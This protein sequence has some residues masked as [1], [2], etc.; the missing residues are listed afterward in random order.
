MLVALADP[1]HALPVQGRGQS[2]GWAGSGILTEATVLIRVLCPFPRLPA[3]G[4]GSVQAD[5]GLHFD[6]VLQGDSGTY[7]CVVTNAAGSQHRDVELIV[8]G[9]SG[10]PR[11][12]KETR[13]RAL[14][15]GH[16]CLKKLHRWYRG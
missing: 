7:S 6:R 8:Q 13:G 9:E 12:G 14:E 4:R 16:F 11:G 2:G 10:D 5:G 15:A 3:G 1:P